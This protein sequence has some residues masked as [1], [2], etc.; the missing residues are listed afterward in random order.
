MC[1]EAFWHHML[2]IHIRVALPRQDYRRSDQWVRVQTSGCV[3]KQWDIWLGFLACALVMV[4]AT[5]HGGCANTVKYSTE[6]AQKVDPGRKIRCRTGESNPQQNSVCVCVC[7]CARVCVC[8]CVCVCV[9][10]CA[11][12]SDTELCVCVCA[13]V[14]ACARAR[15]TQ[16]YVC[17]CVYV[18]ACVRAC[19]RVC[20]C[21]HLEQSLW[22]MF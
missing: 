11:R 22:E 21:V 2:Q 15:L 19:V 10:V 14:R 9:C 4:H 17:V 20:V 5:V 7:V 3:S 6:S 1:L 18:R 12:A 16:N 13:C 8:E